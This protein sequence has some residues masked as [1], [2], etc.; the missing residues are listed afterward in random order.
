[1]MSAATAQTDSIHEQRTAERRALSQIVVPP[2]RVDASGSWLASPGT[3]R[4]YD[5]SRSGLLRDK[6]SRQLQAVRFGAISTTKRGG[7]RQSRI[8]AARNYYLSAQN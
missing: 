1:M 4:L 7:W 3:Q 6:T 8:R 2:A 5:Q